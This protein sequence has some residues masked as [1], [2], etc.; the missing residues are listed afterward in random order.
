MKTNLKMGIVLILVSINA[1]AFDVDDYRYT[2]E[3]T[4]D[5]YKKANMEK[6][7]AEKSYIAHLKIYRAQL[8]LPSSTIARLGNDL[9][10]C[11][12]LEECAN[13]RAKSK[14]LA[15]MN[16]LVQSPLVRALAVDASGLDQLKVDTVTYFDNLD[17]SIHTDQKVLFV[18]QGPDM[19]YD[20][21]VDEIFGPGLWG[22]EPEDIHTEYRANRDAYLKSLSEVKLAYG[23]YLAAKAAFA[24]VMKGWLNYTNCANYG[25]GKTVEKMITDGEL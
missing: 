15:E 9:K 19:V 4:R 2:F 12:H 7:L 23:P 17:Y 6:R 22:S 20:D 14:V 21:S 13:A 1:K 16:I 10:D 3:S 5:S 8:P 11:S 24:E 25:P 18:D